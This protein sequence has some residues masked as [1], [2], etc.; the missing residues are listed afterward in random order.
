MPQ[1]FY[2]DIIDPDNPEGPKTQATIPH[3]LI[4]QYYKYHPVRYENFRA[5]KFV[6]ENPAR[7][8]AGVRQFNEGG[9]CFTGRPKQWYVKADAI[10]PFPDELVFA[11][12]LNS[13]L[14]VYEA[15]A[16]KSASDDPL[17]PEDWQDRYSALVWKNTF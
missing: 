5:A 17:C 14:F 10:V 7:I 12:Y 15:R 3:R 1:N 4:L 9:W 6:L 11:V 13:R 2:I 8:F 16:E